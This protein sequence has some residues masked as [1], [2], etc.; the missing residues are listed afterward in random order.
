[1]R[2]YRST[3]T[4]SSASA[5]PWHADTLFGHLCWSLLR[6]E[7]EDFLTELVL[8]EYSEN[9]PP[10]L[11]SDGFPSGFLPRPRVSPGTLAAPTSRKFDRVHAYRAVKDELDASWLQIAEFEELIR[12]HHVTPSRQPE[13]HERIVTKNQI[14]RS[15]DTAGGLGGA[16]FEFEEICLSSVDVYWGIA[17]GYEALVESFLSDLRFTGY[18]KRRTVGYGAV[19]SWTFEPFGGFGKVPDSNGFVTLCN[20]V[21]AQSDPR[22][23][24]WMTTVKYGKLGDEF[25]ST[26]RPFKRPLLQL[27]AGSCFY[28]T[29]VRDWYGR[30]IGDIAADN[31]V[32]QYAFAFP[33]AMKLPARFEG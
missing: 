26:A 28:D 33:V 19:E 20:F 4:L 21:P 32:V 12:G 3:L 11:L 13:L 16:L 8:Q 1:M 7:G 9:R 30:L 15:T 18:G 23:G 6:R 25:A 29:P 17:E 5:T 22:S 14:D 2:L 27:V 31:R 24:M 10:I